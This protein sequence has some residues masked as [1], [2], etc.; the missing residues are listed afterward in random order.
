MAARASGSS[1]QSLSM[2]QRQL[3]LAPGIRV[4]ADYAHTLEAIDAARADT[5][6]LTAADIIGP[7][8][9][10]QLG[11]DLEARSVSLIVAPALTDVAGPRV[12]ARPVAGL[13]LIHVEYPGV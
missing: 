9:M 4:I 3:E 13:P 8:Q 1:A 11:W 6:V 2:A 5:V 10:R 12:H 7:Q